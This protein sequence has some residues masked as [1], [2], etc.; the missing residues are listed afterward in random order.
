[1]EQEVGLV[2]EVQCIVLGLLEGHS[3]E[4]EEQAG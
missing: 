4:L 1:V 2:E 3:L